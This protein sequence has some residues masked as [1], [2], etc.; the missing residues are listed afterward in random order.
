MIILS[1]KMFIVLL[2]E[3]EYRTV[4]TRANIEIIYKT[5]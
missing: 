2:Q 5:T 3:A 1:G 4:D